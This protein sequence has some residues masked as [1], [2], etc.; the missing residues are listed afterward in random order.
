MTLFDKLDTNKDGKLQPDEL[1]A[2]RTQ[3]LWFG[4]GWYSAAKQAACNYFD[5][6]KGFCIGNS[7][8]APPAP[9]A[10]QGAGHTGEPH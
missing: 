7:G 8:E 2:A 3:Q 5:A 10:S 9:A 1:A 4:Q 6:L